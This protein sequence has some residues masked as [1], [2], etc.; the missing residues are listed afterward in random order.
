MRYLILLLIATLCTNFTALAREIK[1]SG[2]ALGAMVRL[3][4]REVLQLSEVPGPRPAE[5]LQLLDGLL[6]RAPKILK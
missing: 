5:L 6:L 1:P 2:S 3:G 4:L